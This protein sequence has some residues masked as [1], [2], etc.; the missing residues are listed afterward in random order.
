MLKK[1]AFMWHVQC[2][3][4]T[5]DCD[6][7]LSF[8]GPPWPHWHLIFRFSEDCWVLGFIFYSLFRMW[9]AYL[10]QCPP[11]FYSQHCIFYFTHI[12]T[13]YLLISILQCLTCLSSCC[14]NLFCRGGNR[15]GE[16]HDTLTP[17]GLIPAGLC[18]GRTHS[19]LAL[20]E[21]QE[22]NILSLY[23]L[24]EE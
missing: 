20:E 4:C 23:L 12:H 14:S 9:W 18:G 16:R 11:F 13:E 3:H 10:F 2:V 24:A 6:F 21:C 17:F 5:S 22:Q 19:L 1:R 15:A 8:T 7:I